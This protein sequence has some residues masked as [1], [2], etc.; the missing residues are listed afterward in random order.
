MH[1][2][3]LS[4]LKGFVIDS[5][6]NDAWKQLVDEADLDSGM[7]L[8]TQSY[9]DSTVVAIIKTASEMTGTS[10]PELQRAFGEYLSS[11]LLQMYDSLIDTDWTALDLIEHT[12]E[13]IHTVVRLQKPN[14]SPPELESERH[15]PDEVVV[16]YGSDRQLC[17][18]AK[19]IIQGVSDHYN[20]QLT[21]KEPQ[22]MHRG[23]PQCKLVVSS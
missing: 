14:A 7:F 22:C 13:Q 5:H 6:G 15:S 3:I 1:G 23:H 9:D 4:K 2:I 18:V 11:D 21:I 8:P 10:S 19:G 20:E 16:R 12:E 17:D